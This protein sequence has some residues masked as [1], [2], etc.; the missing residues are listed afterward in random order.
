MNKWLGKPMDSEQTGP[1]A[2]LS[3]T[4]LTWLDPGSNLGHGGGK[5]ATN[6]LSYSTAYVTL[7]KGT[8]RETASQTSLPLITKN[9]VVLVRKWTMPTERPPRPAKLLLTIAGRLRCM[10]CAADLC[11]RYS[12][13]SRL[14]PLFV[15]SSSSSLILRR[16]GGPRSRP[17]AS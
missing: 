5:P 13:F 15:H 4:D 7:R 6:S 2:V 14:N 10:V 16:L 9:S 11:G 8:G 1:S 3:T 17:T 12:R